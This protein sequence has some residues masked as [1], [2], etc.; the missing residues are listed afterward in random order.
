MADVMRKDARYSDAI[1]T[2]RV[3][4]RSVALA[5]KGQWYVILQKNMT[6]VRTHWIASGL[7]SGALSTIPTQAGRVTVSHGF[8]AWVR[9]CA[10]NL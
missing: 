10:K 1:C 7:T 6:Q 3:H 5:Y 8:A 4:G 2:A 9:R